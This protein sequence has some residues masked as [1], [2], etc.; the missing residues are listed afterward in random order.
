MIRRPPRSTLFPYTTLFRS[1]ACADAPVAPRQ[2]QDT[3]NR[4]RHKA[5]VRHLVRHA[6]RSLVSGGCRSLRVNR[7]YGEYWVAIGAA[8]STAENNV[9]AATAPTE[10][11]VIFIDEQ[12]PWR[13]QPPDLAR[14]VVWAEARVVPALEEH[15]A[16]TMNVATWRWLRGCARPKND[17][18]RDRY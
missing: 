1:L 18:Q 8:N 5:V 17:Q 11:K 4:V 2:S 16:H 3:G 6:A 9:P 7:G 10:T 14:V 15:S 12:R 13:L